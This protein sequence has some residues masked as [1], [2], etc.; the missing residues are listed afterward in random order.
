MTRYVIKRSGS[1]CEDKE[2]Q[3]DPNAMVHIVIPV[4]DQGAWVLHLL[5]NLEAIYRATKDDRFNLILVDYK[6]TDLD[7]QA[8]LEN[9]QL[10]HVKLV[11]LPPPFSRAA[12]V[13]AGIDAVSNP[14]DIILTCDLHLEIPPGLLAEVRRS[15]IQVRKD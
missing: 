12:G 15:T 7:V 14:N 10:P 1:L 5:E 6:S 11:T 2:F 9:F 4:R 3:F 13:Q 8:A